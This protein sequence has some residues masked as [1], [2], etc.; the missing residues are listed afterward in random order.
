MLGPTAAGGH[1]KKGR[2]PRKGGGGLGGL[3][4]SVGDAG[5]S[6]RATG[7]HG[8]GSTGK[9]KGNGN[10]V[11]VPKT[12]GGSGGGFQFS[13][14]NPAFQPL[15]DGLNS[16]LSGAMSGSNAPGARGPAMRGDCSTSSSQN[17]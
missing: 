14:K 5:S 13:V 16:W 7:G 17:H 6:I 3:L 4:A 11:T 12:G 15:A 1:R 10:G 9:G 2:K 8:K